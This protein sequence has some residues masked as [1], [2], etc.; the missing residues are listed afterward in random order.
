MFALDFSIRSVSNVVSASRFL[1]DIVNDTNEAKETF[2]C[3]SNLFDTQG[4]EAATLAVTAYKL[5]LL[6]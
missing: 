3:K 6:H 1:L 5:I 4:A 2:H